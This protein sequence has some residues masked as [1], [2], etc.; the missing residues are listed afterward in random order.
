MQSKDLTQQ[1]LTFS[2][3][4]NPIKKISKI[5]SVVTETAD[6]TVRGTDIVCEYHID[7]NLPNVEADES[8]MN[9]VI[10]NLI[11]N[12][13]NAMDNK[14]VITITISRKISEPYQYITDAA[15]D[16]F[17]QIDIRDTGCGIDKEIIDKI[18]DP[19]F[20]TKADGSGLGLAISYSIV[21]KHGGH[22]LVQ[23]EVGVGS[24]FSILLPISKKI[25]PKQQTEGLYLRHKNLHLL[26]MD[27]EKQIR[28]ITGKLLS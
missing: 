3:G 28:D 18:F 6:Y 25:E 16:D 8:Q 1:L 15:K 11:T 21:K 5:S 24:V 19:Y 26:V 23:S 10:S 22:L 20:T 13:M 4:G 27:D 12:A 7:D 9:Q 2:R 17:I 14:G